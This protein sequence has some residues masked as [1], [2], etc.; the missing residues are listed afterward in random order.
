MA[1]NKIR[2][3]AV[4]PMIGSNATGTVKQRAAT[5]SGFKG[6]KVKSGL[7]GSKGGKKTLKTNGGTSGIM[8]PPTGGGV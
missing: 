1:K 7:S 4:A 8:N 3:G 5:P 2:G 6:H